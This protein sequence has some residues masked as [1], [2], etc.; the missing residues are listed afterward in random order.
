M[1]ANNLVKFQVFDYWILLRL[2][3]YDEV[4]WRLGLWQIRRRVKSFWGNWVAKFVFL[5]RVGATFVNQ[6]SS[7]ASASPVK[8]GTG[9][10]LTSRNYL[11]WELRYVIWLIMIG[12][13][14][15]FQLQGWKAGFI[16]WFCYS[17]S[18]SMLIKTIQNIWLVISLDYLCHG[19]SFIS[20][21]LH[22]CSNFLPTVETWLCSYWMK[23]TMA[24]GI[25]QPL[26]SPF[27]QTSTAFTVPHPPYNQGSMVYKR[28]SA[29]YDVF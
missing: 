9:L 20:F 5:L 21:T 23:P 14:F 13:W 2:Q 4:S 25:V 1:P 11:K 3:N 8:V 6:V 17:H 18:V 16:S 22:L 10:E 26:Q 28:G 24:L 15:K 7:L 12:S 27:W 29:L 19:M